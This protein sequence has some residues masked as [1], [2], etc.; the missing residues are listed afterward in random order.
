MIHM[1]HATT[2][3]A[4]TKL[5]NNQPGFFLASHSLHSTVDSKVNESDN[6]KISSGCD[7][8]SRVVVL[9]N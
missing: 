4:F 7:D 2:V 9:P 3:G 8:D 6:A 1:V 5:S